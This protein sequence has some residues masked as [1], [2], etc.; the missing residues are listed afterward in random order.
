MIFLGTDGDDVFLWSK[1]AAGDG[2]I[3][4]GIFGECLL[5]PLLQLVAVADDTEDGPVLEERTSSEVLA[6]LSISLTTFEYTR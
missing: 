5:E 6:A 1:D 3:E 4:T 2:T